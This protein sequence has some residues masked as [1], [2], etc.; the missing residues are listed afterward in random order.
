MEHPF[1]YFLMASAAL[2][3]AGLALFGFTFSG[4]PYSVPGPLQFTSR[5]QFLTGPPAAGETA[6]SRPVT[7]GLAETL[8]PPV[9]NFSAAVVSAQKP[10]LYEAL[11][12]Q[13]SLFTVDAAPEFFD[14]ERDSVIMI[15]PLLP[16]QLQMYFKDR[17][18]VHME[19]MFTIASAG[20]RRHVIIKRKVSSGN[21][22][23]D[24]LCARYLGHYLFIQQARF[25]PNTWQTVKIDLSQ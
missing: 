1:K 4:I 12:M 19:L 2:H 21:L 17:Q 6:I 14:R 22:D 18:S 25:V 23:A 13:K 20:S 5:G 15:H 8:P 7:A 10:R 3:T 24:L 11:L 16:F 9:K